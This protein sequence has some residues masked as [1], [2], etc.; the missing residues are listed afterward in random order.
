LKI[1]KN[2]EVVEEIVGSLAKEALKE[3]IEGNL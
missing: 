1:F 2:G 3:K